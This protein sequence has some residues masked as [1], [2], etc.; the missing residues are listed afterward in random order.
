MTLL[1]LAATTA[2]A[3][4]LTLLN[5]ADWTVS[6]ASMSPVPAAVPGTVPAALWAASGGAQSDA[7]TFGFNQRTVLAYSTAGNF[8]YTKVFRTPDSCVG[9]GK[10][11]LIFDGVDTVATI[12]LNGREIGK[13][14]NMHLRY[15]FDATAALAQP[16]GATNTLSIE[17]MSATRAG[18]AAAAAHG[19]PTC[20]KHTRT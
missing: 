17:L 4:V 13:V 10:C 14:E 20:K 12:A 18:L 1:L 15:V 5:G 2:P 19:D 8:T 6:N 16:S 9:S 7:P 3:A 11:E